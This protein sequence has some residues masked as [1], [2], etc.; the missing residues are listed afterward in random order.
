[1]NLNELL[2][3]LEKELAIDADVYEALKVKLA[4]VTDLPGLDERIK[5]QEAEAKAPVDCL[6]QAHDRVRSITMRLA[7]LNRTRINLLD[8]IKL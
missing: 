2:D 6:P 8:C 5:Q 4:T 7:Q 1:M 3:V